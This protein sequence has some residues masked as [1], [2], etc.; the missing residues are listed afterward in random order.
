MRNI[1]GLKSSLTRALCMLLCL[2]MLFLTV[3]CSKGPD[4]EEGENA[5]AAQTTT[6]DPSQDDQEEALYKPEEKKYNRDLNCY[7][8]GNNNYYSEGGQYNGD[9]IND[10][11]YKRYTYMQEVYAVTV[12]VDSTGT[13]DDLKPA[14]MSGENVCDF[15]LLTAKPSMALAQQGLYVDI[16]SLNNMNLTA[17]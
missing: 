3:A 1:K 10:A 6:N 15:A 7:A 2:L 14:L 17:S 11:V 12:N 16:N 9:S 4:A 8:Q 13:A 5:D